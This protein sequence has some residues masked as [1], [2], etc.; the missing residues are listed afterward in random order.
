MFWR[1]SIRVL[2]SGKFPSIRR[3]VLTNVNPP[4]P[5]QLIEDL[6]KTYRLELDQ[7]Q[8]NETERT[9]ERIRYLKNILKFIDRRKQLLIDV[10]ETSQLS[11]GEQRLV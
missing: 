6:S 10:N 9:I 7:L 8:K 11:A 4:T 3:T 1:R 5:D 2:L